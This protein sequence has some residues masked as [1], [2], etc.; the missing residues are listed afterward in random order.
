MS[1]V[2]INVTFPEALLAEIDAAARRESRSRSELL[3]AA[4]R[5]YV[6]RQQRWQD[7]F[8]LGD[9]IRRERGLTEDDVQQEIDA[10]RRGRR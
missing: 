4:A 3:R 9:R 5:L 7:V 2:T 6:E 10:V 1:R 8:R